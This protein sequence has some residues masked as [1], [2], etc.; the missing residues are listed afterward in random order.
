MDR[1]CG[2]T[3]RDVGEGR[4]SRAAV[5]EPRHPA[6]PD[7]DGLHPSAAVFRPGAA[8][9]LRVQ[10][11][12]GDQFVPGG[13]QA[14]PAGRHAPLGD[15]ACVGAEHQSAD[16]PGAGETGGG[17]SPDGGEARRAGDAAGAGLYR[18]ACHPLFHRARC[19]SREA[20]CSLCR[21]DENATAAVSGR[22]DRR[23]ALRGSAHGS[24]ALGLL[25]ARWQ[26]E[27][28]GRGHRGHTRAGAD[29]QPQPSR[30]L[31]LLHPRGGGLDPPRA[32]APLRGTAGDA[33]SGRGPSRAH[34]GPHLS[35]VG[36]L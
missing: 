27:G 21:C 16:G 1:P 10:P 36:A 31:P 8:A 20:G 26:A 2:P 7:H 33:G 19:L 32:G 18:G 17:R 9:G 11:R 14:R 4:R 5:L 22:C 25:D 15:R 34:A 13:S 23:H 3:A 29:D 30:R 12:R 35:P 24:A 28:P 6:P